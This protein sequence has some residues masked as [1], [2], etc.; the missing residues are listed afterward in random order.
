MSVILS[1][2]PDGWEPLF[3]VMLQGSSLFLH[4]VA[5]PSPD[6]VCV[7]VLPSPSIKK[8]GNYEGVLSA[9]LKALP[10]SSKRHLHLP[11]LRPYTGTRR[12]GLGVDSRQSLPQVSHVASG[13]SL[14]TLSY[15]SP[16]LSPRKPWPSRSVVLSRIYVFMNTPS[17]CRQESSRNTVQDVIRV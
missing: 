16:G 2:C 3:H 1:G 15:G 10:W 14:R 4:L 11:S 6:S 5:L 9:L 17:D 12:E 7:F 8:E 13:E